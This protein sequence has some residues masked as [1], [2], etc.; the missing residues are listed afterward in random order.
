MIFEH[1]NFDVK[2]V[3]KLQHFQSL[4][5]LSLIKR[6]V[7]IVLNFYITRKMEVEYSCNNESN[8]VVRR[9]HYVL[10]YVKYDIL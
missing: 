9:S 7:I 4:V 6:K 1:Q 10:I 2:Y 3:C 8:I 5:K